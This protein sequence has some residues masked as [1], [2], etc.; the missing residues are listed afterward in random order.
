M[1]DAL[2]DHIGE[3]VSFNDLIIGK[4]VKGK[5]ALDE[6][7]GFFYIDQGNLEA[8]Y[9]PTICRESGAEEYHVVDGEVR[10]I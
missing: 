9:R 5:L 2:Q 3:E 6:T 7:L 1:E 4:V 8:K 10:K